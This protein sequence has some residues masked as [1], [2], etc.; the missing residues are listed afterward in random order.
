MTS[1]VSVVKWSFLIASRWRECHDTSRWYRSVKGVVLSV[2][3]IVGYGE[4]R[5]CAV[6]GDL[7]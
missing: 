2:L 1:V 5:S 7:A 6:L 3:K 4:R